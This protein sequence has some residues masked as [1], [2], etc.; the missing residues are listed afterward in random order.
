MVW[1]MWRRTPHRLTGPAA[2][3]LLAGCIVVPRTADVYDPQCRTY[4]RQVV[5]ETEVIGA[6]GG[7]RNDGC[8]VMLASMG[9]ISAASAVVSGSIAVV[10]NMLYWAE[11]R[12]Q[13]PPESAAVPPPAPGVPAS[14]PPPVVPG[15][16]PSP[17]GV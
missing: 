3:L 9:V 1:G 13:C 16:V 2:A 11:R 5:L 4:V 6:I 7:C 8:V 12:G 10:G 14:G 17:R 15:L